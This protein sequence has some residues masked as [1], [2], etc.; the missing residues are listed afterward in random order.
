MERTSNG[1]LRIV[2]LNHQ[3]F[4]ADINTKEGKAKDDS[5]RK[6]IKNNNINVMLLAENNI[7]WQSVP[8][9]E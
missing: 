1:S 8:A 9:R 2:F 3:G 4:A 6:F 5:L 7:H